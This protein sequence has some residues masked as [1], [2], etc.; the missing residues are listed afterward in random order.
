MGS[1]RR[2]LA[3]D[4]LCNFRIATKGVRIV[5]FEFG[6][7][8]FFRRVDRADKARHRSFGGGQDSGLPALF[9]ILD[10]GS[11]QPGG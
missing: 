1:L 3:S 8:R 2:F 7:G 9:V 5:S 4:R 11:H 10:N 6:V